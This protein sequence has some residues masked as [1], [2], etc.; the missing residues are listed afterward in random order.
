MG[1]D[2]LPFPDLASCPGRV[3]FSPRDPAKPILI[4]YWAPVWL[5]DW[6]KA[7]SVTM[8]VRTFRLLAVTY[9][10][11]PRLL[12][13]GER[14]SWDGHGWMCLRLSSLCYH[15][16]G[17]L[18]RNADVSDQV[19]DNEVVAGVR[20]SCWHR[21]HL[22]T[23]NQLPGRVNTSTGDLWGVETVPSL[24]ASR[25]I[26][27]ATNIKIHERSQTQKVTYYKT[28]YIKFK[29]SQSYIILFCNE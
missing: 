3:S 2:S 19:C 27:L 25:C 26:G 20:W 7:V 28:I 10:C 9:I 11:S 4:P 13:S 12:A 6:D 21:K 5:E 1:L 18:I 16:L 17:T 14:C 22:L 24:P 15:F 29:S 23:R 8:Q